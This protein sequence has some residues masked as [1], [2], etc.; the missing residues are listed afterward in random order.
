MYYANIGNFLPEF[1]CPNQDKLVL[2]GVT[3]ILTCITTLFKPKS[4]IFCIIP[5]VLKK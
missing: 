2:L 3:N 1:P 4:E 5:N